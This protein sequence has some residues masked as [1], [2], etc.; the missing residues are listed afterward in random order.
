MWRGPAGESSFTDAKSTIL[1]GLRF[2]CW[3]SSHPISFNITPLFFSLLASFSSGDSKLSLRRRAASN[4]KADGAEG[5]RLLMTVAKM[6]Y[7][8]SL[9]VTNR[10]RNVHQAAMNHVQL[11]S[12]QSLKHLH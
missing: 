2:L 11:A 3:C 1:F 9:E 6:F 7:F 8:S 5:F 12:V 10:K 4:K